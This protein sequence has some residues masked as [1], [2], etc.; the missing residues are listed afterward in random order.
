MCLH[1]AQRGPTYFELTNKERSEGWDVRLSVWSASTKV[2]SWWV[3]GPWSSTQLQHFVFFCW[4]RICMATR[5]ILNVR[6]CQN[7]LVLSGPKIAKNSYYSRFW[8]VFV[9]SLSTKKFNELG[10]M[11]FNIW[12]V[13]SNFNKKLRNSSKNVLL[14][15]RPKV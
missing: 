2:A 3:L 4:I 10:L 8:S 12:L 15:Y 11:R 6:K 13:V 7:F 14:P 5:S 1:D 9:G